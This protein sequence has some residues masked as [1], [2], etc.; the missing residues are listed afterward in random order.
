MVATNTYLERWKDTVLSLE[1][2]SLQNVLTCV[3]LFTNRPAEA[4]TWSHEKLSHVKVRVYPID[5]WGWPEA[6]LLRYEFFQAE[7]HQIYEPVLMYLDS[8]MEVRSDFSKLLEPEEWI[9]GLAFVKHPGYT[10]PHGVA[11]LRY[12]LMRPRKMIGYALGLIG[13]GGTSGSWETRPD[14]KAY[15]PRRM[16]KTYVHGAVWFGKNEDFKKLCRIL[17][18][19]TREDLNIGVIAVWHDESHLNWY[20]ANQGGTVLDNRFSGVDGY[21][22]LSHLEACIVT[23]SKG[24]DEGREPTQEG[25]F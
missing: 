24:V 18:I 6:T 9:H 22:N 12:L 3:H 23:V 14:S 11:F 17:A 10:L 20:L 7:L 2:A 13:N 15:V 1:K 4:L 19:R 16:R 25:I 5:A 8:D 21:R